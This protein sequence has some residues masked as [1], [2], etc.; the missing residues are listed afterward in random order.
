MRYRFTKSGSIVE[1]I[2]KPYKVRLGQSTVNVVS[3]KRVDN[4]KELTVPVRALVEI[5]LE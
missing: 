3:V 5:P 1:K 2:G 4:G